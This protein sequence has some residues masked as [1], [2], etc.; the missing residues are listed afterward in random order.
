MIYPQVWPW[1]RVGAPEYLRPTLVT[2]PAE[3]P[4]SLAE[5]KAHL[6]KDDA[7]EDGLI[8]GLIAAAVAHLDGSTGVLGRCL[9]E[10]T[11]RQDLDGWPCDGA[12]RIPLLPV[13]SATV[14]YVVPDGTP[15]ALPTDQFD[16]VT[17]ARGGSLRRPEGVTWPQIATRPDAVRVTFVAGYGDAAAVPQAIKHAILLLVGHWFENREAVQI[18]QAPMELPLAVDALVRPYR[19]VFF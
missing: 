8:G 16:L 19:E 17:D 14:E 3:M 1:M 18:G 10:Q 12:V 7:D 9:I 13:Q 5:A 6:R 15:I 4:V 11:W 2:P